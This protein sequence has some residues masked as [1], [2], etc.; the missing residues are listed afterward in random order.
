M[1]VTAPHAPVMVNEVLAAL[2]PRDGG[3]YVD[4][5]FGAGGYARALLGAARCTVVAIDRDPDAVARGSDLARRYP[6]RLT[7]LSGRFGTMVELLAAI[8]TTRV[9]GIA[10]DLGVSS[11]Q[12]DQP[13]RGFSFRVDGPLDMRMERRGPSAADVVNRLAERELADI[14]YTFGEERASRRIAH[15]IVERR[16]KMPI[17]RTGQLAELVRQVV[18]KSKDGI[19]PATRTFQALRIY[20][21]DE[22]GE[23]KRGLLAAEA[24]LARG[25][26]IAVVSFH[27]LEDRTVKEFLRARSDAAARP[28][29]HA[30]DRLVAKHRPTFRLLTRGAVKPTA[31]EVA[32]NPRARSA[33]LRAAERTDAAPWPSD[34]RQAA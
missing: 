1:T 31:A 29:R 22:I 9:D 32:A 3:T 11:M 33:R 20:I 27:S 2:V 19:D 28:S 21:N 30:P 14:I 13:E 4:A 25:G 8:G 24:L 7:V 26:R 5:T 10:F 17:T 15:A 18:T 12:L 6:G 16:A 23:L 34:E